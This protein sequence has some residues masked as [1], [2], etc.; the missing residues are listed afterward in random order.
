MIRVGN[1]SQHAETVESVK[2]NSMEEQVLS[3][4][5]ENETNISVTIFLNL[6]ME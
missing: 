6:P 3:E 1:F 5:M 2:K 4:K